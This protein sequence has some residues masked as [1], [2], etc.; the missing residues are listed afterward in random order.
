MRFIPAVVRPTLFVLLAIGAALPARAVAAIVDPGFT[1][2]AFV[3]SAELATATGLAWAPDASNRLFITKKEG[4]IRIIKAGVLLPTPF[5]TVSPLFTA[6]ECGVIGIAFDPDFLTN[7]YV[8]IFATV[9]GSEQQIIRYTVTGDVGT[10]KTPIVTGLPTRGVNHDGGAIGFGPDG[11]MYWAIGDQGN[12]TGVDGDLASLAAKVGR[13]NLDGSVP[14]DNPFF[15]GAGPNADYIWAR[16]FRNPFTMA[17]QPATGLMWLNVVG[18]NYEQIF[19]VRRGDHGGWDNYENNQPGGFI[20]PVIKYRTNVNDPQTIRPVAMTGAVRA[21]GVATYSTTAAHG[22]RV[23]EKITIAGVADA[24]FNTSLFVVAVP[25]PTS[26]TA[27]QPGADAQSGDGT[28]TPLNQGGCVTG[29]AFYEASQFPAAYRG[30]FFYGDYNTWRIMRAT[31]DPITNAVT[32]VDSFASGIT[33]I[34]DVTVGPDG[35]LYYVGAASNTVYRTSYNAALQGLVVSPTVLWPTEGQSA[36]FSVRLQVAPAADVSVTVAR[37]AGDTD[38]AVTS[39]S[40][41]TFTA[42]NWNVPQTVTVTAMSDTDTSDDTATLSVSSAALGAEAV[43]VRARDVGA[44][45]LVISQAGLTI[46]EGASGTF[47]VALSSAP[48]ADVTVNVARTAGDDSV[49]VTGGGALTFTPANW[50][51]AQTVTVSAA[52]DAD[53]TADTATVSSTSAG[54]TTRTVAVTA[55]D[56]DAVAPAITSTAVT[57]GVVG[58]PYGYDVEAT[59]LPPPTFSLDSTV[60]GMTIAAST[61]VISWTPGTAGSFPVVLRA[62]NGV[63]PD[64]TQSF[65]VVVAADQ[66]PTCLVTR[67]TAGE[68][69]A[70]SR[71]SFSAT[72]WTTSAPSGRSFLSTAPCATRTSAARVTITSAARTTCGTPPRWPTARTRCAS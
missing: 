64:A 28:A 59:G 69:V 25:S 37:T 12:G 43:S 30:N 6:S 14:N 27:S 45:A 62:A 71:R 72:A 13:A 46:N 35:A 65:T 9:S 11:K 32:T 29:G 4:E 2:A 56:N 22:F 34:V 44:V 26:F 61:G 21:G 15:D 40:T 53:A 36:V 33:G 17:F 51:V 63:T 16:G 52:E 48:A 19:I 41:L 47:T 31:I 1:E 7:Q 57:S 49:T 10:N 58:V 23:G 66:P 39:G 3:A 54:L 42:A 67:P 5:A 38:I 60:A 55:R 50:S 24:S 68:T 20:T 70:G 18:T 8:Y